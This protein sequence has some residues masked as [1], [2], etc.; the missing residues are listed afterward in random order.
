MPITSPSSMPMWLPTGH[1][2]GGGLSSAADAE[3]DV[4]TAALQYRDSTDTADLILSSA[5]TKRLD[6]SWAVGTDQGGLDTGSIANN[7]WYYAW[8]IR[9]PDTGVVDILWSASA[10]SPTMPTSYTQK[11]LIRGGAAAVLTDGSANIRPFS[12]IGSRFR[13]LTHLDELNTSTMPADGSALTV[14]APA[15]ACE[16]IGLAR[17]MR[18]GTSAYFGLYSTLQ[19]ITRRGWNTIV[20]DGFQLTIMTNNQQLLIYNN[21]TSNW[22]TIIVS[23]LGW[24]DTGV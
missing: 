4:T 12:N 7:T 24:N 14:S 17:A 22:S 3:H 23:T 6:A 2:N 19:G 9:R 16:W 10:S 1:R 18:A 11:A 20:D 13:F 5:I 15:C 21:A 8:V